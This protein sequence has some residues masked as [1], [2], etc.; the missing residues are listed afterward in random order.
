MPIGARARQPALSRGRRTAYHSAEKS[1]GERCIRITDGEVART[2][3]LNQSRTADAI[4]QALRTDSRASCWGDEIY[5][6]VVEKGELG[7]WPPGS[8]LCRF[9]GRTPASQADE[10][11]AA[12]P[13]SVSGRIKLGAGD[14]RRVRSGEQVIIEVEPC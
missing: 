2:A 7:Y 1:V 9:R 13:V 11:R 6:H 3:R 10:I 8:A 5:C 14:F 4:C 12:S